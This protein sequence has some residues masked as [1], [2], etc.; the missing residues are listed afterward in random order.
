MNRRKESRV[1]SQF[2]GACA[3]QRGTFHAIFISEMSPNGCRFSEAD[4]ALEVGEVIALSLGPVGIFDATVRWRDGELVGVQFH[5]TLDA[6]IFNH[7]AAYCR[8]AA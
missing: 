2:P 4:G 3:T 7:F 6:A 5:E 8:T 1:Y